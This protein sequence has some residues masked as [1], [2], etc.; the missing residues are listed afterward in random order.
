M[1]NI[2]LIAYEQPLRYTDPHFLA[3][4]TTTRPRHLLAGTHGQ[5]GKGKPE[6]DIGSEAEFVRLPSRRGR[7]TDEPLF[8]YRS[9]HT[10]KDQDA[11]SDSDASLSEQGDVAVSSAESD[12]E[13]NMPRT[14]HQHS[15]SA[16][17]AALQRDPTSL[18][19]WYALLDQT[20]STIPPSSKSSLAKARAEIKL[21]VLDRAIRTHSRNSESI[22][23]R[24]KWLNAGAEAWDGDKL[25]K[26]WERAVSELGGATSG[27]KDKNGSRNRMWEEW[28]RWRISSAG[29]SVRKSA[30]VEG[31][32]SDA[33]RVMENV[34]GEI[35]RVKLLWRIAVILRDAGKF[36]SL[37]RTHN[38]NLMVVQG[39]RNA[40]W[41]YFK[42][43]LSCK[44]AV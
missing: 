30:G 21:S 42:L 35:A 13:S 25:N 37:T 14:A 26:E 5:K 43:K 15:L 31:I 19:S 2:Q 39:S 12:S 16:L 7:S 40:Q 20:L 28:L 1:L 29:R 44:G 23:L 11:N 24:V 27:N 18:S 22:G 36:D 8:T 38:N 34:E 3:I 10:S 17:E 33:K 4:L 9:I 32:M 6:T 41:Q